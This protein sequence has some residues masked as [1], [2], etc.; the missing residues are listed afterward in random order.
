MLH[1]PY[2]FKCISKESEIEQ[3][4]EIKQEFACK[5]MGELRRNSN[6]ICS[7]EVGCQKYFWQPETVSIGE[8]NLRNTAEDWVSALATWP[9]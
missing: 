9:P 1:K 4:I 7:V 3:S 5:A 8:I 2:A 6:N